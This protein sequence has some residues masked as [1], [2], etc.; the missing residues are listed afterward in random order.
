MSHWRTTVFANSRSIADVTIKCGIYQ[1]NAVIPAVL[2]ALLDKSAYGYR[3]KG[4]TTIN[5][6][7]YM[8][9]IKLYAKNEQNIDSLIHLTQVFSSDI[10]MTFG[11]AK[12][13]RLIVN[14]GKVKNTSGISLLER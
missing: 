3:F 10:G 7:L 4:G 6:R 1:R 12:C 14:R 2:G 11:L 9:D 13:R 5:H 8:N